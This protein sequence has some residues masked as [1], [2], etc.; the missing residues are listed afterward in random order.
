VIFPTRIKIIH[1]SHILYNVLTW[2]GNIFF[3]AF[4]QKLEA[5]VS[6]TGSPEPLVFGK[7]NKHS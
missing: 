1:G 6:D 2:V 4:F 7:I 3:T 5:Q